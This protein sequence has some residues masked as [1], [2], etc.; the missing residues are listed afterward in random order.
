MLETIFVT[1]IAQNSLILR[2]LKEIAD[3]HILTGPLICKHCYQALK[4]M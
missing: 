1:S 3:H 4:G 2:H